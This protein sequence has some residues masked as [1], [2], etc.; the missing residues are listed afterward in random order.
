MYKSKKFNF[1]SKN[2]QIYYVKITNIFVTDV[3]YDLW[4]ILE[5][6]A[7]ELLG[8]WGRQ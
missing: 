7:F 1:L 2:I 4:R 3:N 8:Y 6:S 5:Q